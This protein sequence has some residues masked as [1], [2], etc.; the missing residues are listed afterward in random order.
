MWRFRPNDYVAVATWSPRPLTTRPSP[1]LTAL[2]VG[3]ALL[4]E[5]DRALAGVLRDHHR[6]GDLA[7]LV[8]RLGLAPVARLLHDPLRGLERER[9]VARDLAGELERHVDRSAG[10]GQPVDDPELVGAFRVDRVPGERQLHGQVIGD[11]L[12][13]ADQRAAGRNEAALDLGDA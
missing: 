10:F 7:L 13:K 3:I 1:E 11:P 6:T 9:A 2:P 12:R 8:P 4:G 5:R